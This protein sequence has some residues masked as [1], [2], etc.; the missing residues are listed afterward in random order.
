MQEVD[1]LIEITFDRVS[2]HWTVPLKNCLGNTDIC[3][4]DVS[5]ISITL[6]QYLENVIFIICLLV[7]YCFQ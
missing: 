6:N 7:L 3:Q 4:R 5:R 2:F 1:H